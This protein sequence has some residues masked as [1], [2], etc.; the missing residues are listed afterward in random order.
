MPLLSLA[1]LAIAIPFQMNNVRSMVATDGS[2]GFCVPLT[3]NNNGIVY[4][5]FAAI[6]TSSVP[7]PLALV[8]DTGSYV[9]VA[10]STYCTQRACLNHRRFDSNMS[11]TFV[12]E[13][14]NNAFLLRYGQGNITVHDASDQVAFL[15]LERATTPIH[16]SK[17]VD[18][19]LMS[20]QTL[21]GFSD[22]PYDGIMGLGKRKTTELNHQ[23]FLEDMEIEGFTLCLGD[24]ELHGD[25]IGGR[26][27]MQ[28][29][30]DVGNP[31]VTLSTIGKYVW[32][33]MLDHVSVPGQPP[34]AHCSALSE[35]ASIIDSGTTLLLFPEPVVD[36]LYYTIEDGCAE[37]DC[38]L[39]LQNQTT[40]SGPHFDGLP[41]LELRV[42]G[43]MLTLPPRVYM[44]E[45]E[46]DVPTTKEIKVGNTEVS[47]PWY[48]PGVRCIPLLSTIDEQTTYGPMVI[49]G[50]PF[51]RHYSV[52]FNRTTWDM[53][54]AEI[55]EGSDVC[56]K[57]GAPTAEQAATKSAEPSASMPLPAAMN[58]M[59]VASAISLQPGGDPWGSNM[60]DGGEPAPIRTTTDSSD[61]PA[62][63]PGAVAS[64]SVVTGAQ[65]GG[66]MKTSLLRGPS[67]FGVPS[68]LESEQSGWL[69]LNEAQPASDSKPRRLWVL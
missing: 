65:W 8:V 66:P 5:T 36:S 54:V 34:L 33:A 26:L 27:E 15:G 20:D 4:T 63:R 43:Q 59:P 14:P 28:S 67:L 32:G 52:Y 42:G 58:A 19:G 68:I 23:A 13:A 47:V 9:L 1:M 2:N 62:S 18:I 60:N 69:N 21:R 51:L 61:K 49:L 56:S 24:P 45:M 39:T 48:T 30:L 55:K 7:Q 31:Y 35:C 6:G 38:L 44:G 25:G 16:E 50:M 53:S 29:M 12:E 64:A 11:S 41:Q 37:S 3:N 17:L 40:C 22:A 10:A 46:V 57:C